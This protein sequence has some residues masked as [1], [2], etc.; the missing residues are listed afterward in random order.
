MHS[1]ATETNNTTL[2][3][4]VYLLSQSVFSASQLTEHTQNTQTHTFSIE[5]LFAPNV[6]MFIV[7]W[8]IFFSPS[9]DIAFI[10]SIHMNTWTCTCTWCIWCLLGLTLQHLWKPPTHAFYVLCGTYI[11]SFASQS[12]LNSHTYKCGCEILHLHVSVRVCVPVRVYSFFASF[13]LN[14]GHSIL[15][16]FYTKLTGDTACT[17]SWLS[18]FLF[19]IQENYKWHTK[20]NMCWRIS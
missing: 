11:L 9:I 17:N 12:R 10:Y 1:F 8:C 15:C 2:D 3:K 20:I 14:I 18:F 13:V 6:Y 5:S 7:K 19:Q 4:P 16:A